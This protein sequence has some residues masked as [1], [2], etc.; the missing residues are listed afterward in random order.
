MNKKSVDTKK[1]R[2][3][4]RLKKHN[5]SNRSRIYLLVSNKHMTAQ[6][7]DDAAGKTIFTVST[8]SFEGNKKSNKS[9]M[10]SAEK[11]GEVFSEALS[12]AKVDPKAGFVFDRGGNIYHGKVS[13][14]ADTLREKGLTF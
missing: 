3:R 9:N 8:Q 14:F 4:S 13:K 1:L 12:K 6:L 2:I 10:A 11:L 5:R 7:I